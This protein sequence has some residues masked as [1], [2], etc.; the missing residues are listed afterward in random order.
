MRK[1]AFCPDPGGH[2]LLNSSSVEM[3]RNARA[4]YLE[5]FQAGQMCA[6]YAELYRS[7]LR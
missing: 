4:R 2:A 6:S 1:L 7:V 5:L 3:G